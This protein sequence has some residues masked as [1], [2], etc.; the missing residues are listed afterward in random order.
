MKYLILFSLLIFSCATKQ[1]TT[2]KDS[3]KTNASICPEDGV[4]VFEVMSNRS[5]SIEKDGI[6]ALYPKISEGNKTIL[7]FEYKRNEIPNTVDGQY[8]ELVYLEL[9]PENLEIDLKDGELNN[10]SALF[11]R[12]CFCRG[13]TGYYIIN[14]GQL[15]IKKLTENQYKLKMSFKIDEVPQVISE[16]DEVFYI[17]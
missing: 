14:Q 2:E 11:A 17:K 10:V 3:I 4:C 8:S 1:N 13:Q 12:L 7:K 16:I 5:F 9:S 6:G 15:S